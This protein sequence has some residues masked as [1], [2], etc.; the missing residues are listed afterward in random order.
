MVSDILLYL[1]LLRYKLF[2]PYLYRNTYS[3]LTYRHLHFLYREIIES[4]L[5]ELL[6]DTHYSVRIY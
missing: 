6:V 4:F 2:V 1:A 3:K 5:D